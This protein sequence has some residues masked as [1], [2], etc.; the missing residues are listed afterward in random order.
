MATVHPE[1]VGP[2]PGAALESV[3]VEREICTGFIVA[4]RFVRR[5]E[6]S[7][8]DGFIGIA[9]FLLGKQASSEEKRKLPF[10]A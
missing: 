9:V 8:F 1:N 2:I 10:Q 3:E 6:D 4:E 5:Q 7:T